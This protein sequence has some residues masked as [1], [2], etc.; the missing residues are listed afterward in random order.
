MHDLSAFC[1]L[2]GS[3]VPS[4]VSESVLPNYGSSLCFCF[5]TKCFRRSLTRSRVSGFYTFGELCRYLR[6]LCS[7]ALLPKH[8]PADNDWSC[9]LQLSLDDCRELSCRDFLSR[10]ELKLD[11]DAASRAKARKENSE[12]KNLSAI[13][14]GLTKTVKDTFAAQARSYIVFVIDSLL[15]DIR[16]TA[17]IVRGLAIFNLTVL[18]T[19]PRDQALFWFRALFHSFQLRDFVDGVKKPRRVSIG[20]NMSNFSITCDILVGPSSLLS[21]L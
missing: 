9:L 17:G 15:K 3:I 16:L 6:K 20:R 13:I 5:D 7:R 12:V 10:L 19:Q 2:D 21:P 1:C 18:Q 14:D 8:T 4:S 11:L